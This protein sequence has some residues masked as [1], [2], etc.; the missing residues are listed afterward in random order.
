MTCDLE[1]IYGDLARAVP[2]DVDDAFAFSA[3]NLPPAPERLE[4]DR[5]IVSKSVHAYHAYATVQVDFLITEAHKPTYR[6]LALALL[7]RVFHA[8]PGTIALQLTHTRSEIRAIVLDFD[9]ERD[10]LTWVPGYRTRA[11]RFTYAPAALAAYP[12]ASTP[13]P[14]STLPS[15]NLTNP[16][17]MLVSDADWRTRDIVRCAG[18]DVGHVRL[19]EV[20]L[21]FAR[22]EEPRDEITLESEHSNGGVAR[23]SAEARF[24]LPGNLA[25]SGGL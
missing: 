24:V 11:S 19:A 10:A 23:G 2:T 16:E 3:D 4:S 9:A 20:L 17:N 21:N 6:F 25:W 22:H 1:R 8:A 18:S 12:L 15:F 7:A 13:A 14:E 5:L